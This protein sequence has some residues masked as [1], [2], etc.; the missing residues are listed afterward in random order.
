METPMEIRFGD[1]LTAE[2]DPELY[3]KILIAIAKAD[4]S[5]SRPEFAFIGRQA[6]ALGVDFGHWLKQIGKG[7]AI[8]AIKVSRATAMAVLRDCIHLASMDRNFTLAEKERIYTY[9]AKLDVPRSDLDRLE[10]WVADCR[11]L[12]T[13][14]NALI[15]DAT[16]A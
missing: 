12:E 6:R 1:P 16:T 3:V 14:W 13:R 10:R 8:D 2:F 7:F 11:A 4:P 15:A 9:A 5:N